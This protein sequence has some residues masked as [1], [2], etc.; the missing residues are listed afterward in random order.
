M[1]NKQRSSPSHHDRAGEKDF[2]EQA[3][4]NLK[5]HRE[6][7]SHERSKGE[8]IQQPDRSDRLQTDDGLNSDDIE[9]LRQLSEFNR[10]RATKRTLS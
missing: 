1:L 10:K 2:V 4:D 3:I 6:E 7:Q 5:W 9:Q 8:W